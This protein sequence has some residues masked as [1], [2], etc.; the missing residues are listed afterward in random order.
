MRCPG[1]AEPLRLAGTPEGKRLL[2]TSIYA[3]NG[4]DQEEMVLTIA[5]SLGIPAVALRFFNVYG[6][7]LARRIHI[8][9]SRRSSSALLNGRRL[10]VFED[11]L[12]SR[13]F[14][15]VSDVV[16][17]C[18]LAIERADVSDEALN[19][20]TGRPV[21][22]LEL[23]KKEIPGAFAIEPEILGRFRDGDIRS[24]Y[25]DISR[26]RARLGFEPRVRLEEGVKA[27]ANWVHEQTCEHRSNAALAELQ[28]HGLVR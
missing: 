26:A 25:A 14:I 11:G 8:P 5:R 17:A 28:H 24:C 27:L 2:P 4:R 9:A 7:R 21:N 23:L 19:V 10:V 16:E 1:C 3:I 12:Q 13:D 6:D 20:G 18:L 15:H 22:L